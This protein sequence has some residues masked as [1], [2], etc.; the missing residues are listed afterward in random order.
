MNLEHEHMMRHP[1]SEELR[2]VLLGRFHLRGFRKNQL[3]AI[4]ETL[5]GKDV[6]VLMPTG[7]G[8]S[9]CYQ[10][11]ALFKRGLGLV[12]CPLVALAHDQVAARTQK[13][14]AA[15]AFHSEMPA[16]TRGQPLYLSVEVRPGDE[17]NRARRAPVPQP[18]T[19]AP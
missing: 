16:A 19:C 12:I 14:I 2:S 11:P 15:A 8:K 18:L 6:F 9:L 1:W 4:N 7:G 17:K 10:L 13:G 5:A 3:E